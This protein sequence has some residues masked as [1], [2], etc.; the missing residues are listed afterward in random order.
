MASNLRKLAIF[1][2]DK[3]ISIRNPIL[4]TLFGR[5]I[6]ENKILISYYGSFQKLFFGQC[7]K[8]WKQITCSLA[9]NC[10]FFLDYIILQSG[11]YS[12]VVVIIIILI[13][14]I[15]IIGIILYI[16]I[17]TYIK[18]D[19]PWFYS[20]K[21]GSSHKILAPPKATEVPTEKGMHYLK[22]KS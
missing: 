14:I 20:E 21:T 8:H 3:T 15:S 19:C 11:M 2:Q 16:T 10:Y 22:A 9:Q 13:I 12:R 1:M 5:P 7:W 6:A 4:K 18:Q 17:C